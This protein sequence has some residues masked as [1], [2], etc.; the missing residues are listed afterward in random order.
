LGSLFS[1]LIPSDTTPLLIFSELSTR[2][3]ISSEPGLQARP[4]A[5]PSNILMI[6]DKMFLQNIAPPEGAVPKDKV[7][8]YSRN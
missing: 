6:F 3:L 5:L 4:V 7:C 2:W 8:T 1:Y